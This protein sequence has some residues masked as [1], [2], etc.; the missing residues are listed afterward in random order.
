L[1]ESG[2]S[3]STTLFL[4]VFGAARVATGDRHGA[5]PVYQAADPWGA[6]SH[7]CGAT[8]QNRT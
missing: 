8:E 2:D 6:G 4:G 1:E 7:G 3:L 5:H